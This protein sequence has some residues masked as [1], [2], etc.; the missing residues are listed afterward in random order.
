MRDPK[1]GERKGREKKT[2]KGC[3]SKPAQLFMKNLDLSGKG[4]GTPVAFFFSFL[5]FNIILCLGSFSTWKKKRKLCITT[6]YIHSCSYYY[7]R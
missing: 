3:I 4:Y 1:R 7:K 2:K 6:I 5:L